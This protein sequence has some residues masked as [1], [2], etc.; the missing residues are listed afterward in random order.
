[1]SHQARR[2]QKKRNVGTAVHGAHNIIDVAGSEGKRGVGDAG[3]PLQGRKYVIPI[4][5]TS[6]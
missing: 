6:V 1:M 4:V 5:L 2:A 3:N